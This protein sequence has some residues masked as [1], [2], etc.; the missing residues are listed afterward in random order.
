MWNVGEELLNDYVNN[1]LSMDNWETMKKGISLIIWIF[2]FVHHNH[3]KRT[4]QTQQ[5]TV[6]VVIVI[7]IVVEN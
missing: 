3:T 4:I 1:G 7:V 2:P 5:Q 6:V